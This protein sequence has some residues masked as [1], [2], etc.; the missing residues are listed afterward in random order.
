MKV[1]L[2]WLRDYVPTT[3]PAEELAE[4][5]T[6]AG[7][8]VTGME[9]RGGGW[10]KVW[11]GQ[12]L[13]VSP[14]PN[15]DRLRLVDVDIGASR[16]TVVSGAPNLRVGDKVPFA[17]VGARLIDG[18]TGQTLEL[19]PV[20]IRGVASAGMVC[21]EKELGLSDRH[22]GI[23][24]LPPDAPVGVPLSRYL[25]DTI[26]DIDITPN[27]PDCLSVLGVAREVASRTGQKLS[28]PPCDYPEEG[29]LTEEKASAEILD[30][31]LCPRYS[32]GLVLGVKVGPSPSWLR[33][34][35]EA[36]GMRPINNV[37]DIT[38]YVMIEMGQPLHAF[39]FDTLRGRRIIVRRARRGEKFTT[40]DGV[41]RELNRQMLVIADADRA[42]AL[43]GIMG[44][45][46]TEVTP[47]TTAVLL[48]AASF[49]FPQIRATSRALGLDTEAVM[50]FGRGLA[51][52]LTVPSLRRAV[53]LI[54]DLAGGKAARGLLD[55]YPGK[56]EPEPILLPHQEMKRL[57]GMELAPE[58]VER[59]LT[60]LGFECLAAPSGLQVRV[61]YWR[62]DI[63]L[64]ADL[65]EEVARLWGYDN[66]PLTLISGAPPRPRPNPLL[67]L[68]ERLRDLLVALG[69]QEAIN[70]ALTSV[71]QLEGVKAPLGIK[72]ANPLTR[73]Q[74]YLR[75]SLRPGLLSLLAQ[76]QKYDEVLRFFE[77]GRVYLTREKD[78]PME[79]EVA[80]VVVA[81]RRRPL[82]WAEKEG[83]ADFYDIKGLAQEL[84]S[85][86][87]LEPHFL[88]GQDPFLHPARQ[89]YIMVAGNPTGVLGEVHPQVA[90]G[91]ELKGPAYL[92]E[93]DLTA[94]LPNLP[95]HRPYRPLARFPAVHRD[96]A[97][98]VDEGVPVEK[99]EGI[100]RD[101]LMVT[102]VTLF[103]VYSGKQVPQGK[104]SLAFRVEYQSLGRT[105]TDDEVDAVLAETL[106]RL[107]KD[108]GAELRT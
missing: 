45:L 107:H 34:R 78:L 41:E 53:K 36:Y 35:L 4:K 18:H 99:V 2:S 85:R 86:L 31:D 94:I 98:V 16:E 32:A 106:D 67:Q 80:G 20:K 74:E 97:V 87:G 64:A 43:G 73:E 19:K 33:E 70:Y 57:L 79:R 26:L 77:L 100:L 66:V 91:F 46:D 76:N 11:V 22:E 108:L 25:G 83:E 96:I 69:L 58:E 56:T 101:A 5:L 28:L 49:T 54:L 93:L 104:K 15:A 29:P 48:E 30:P 39:D 89:A 47:A 42:V 103:D 40:L 102:G 84:L 60:S 59:I 52:G 75:T 3:L 90:E 1:P 71:G 13:E 95:P 62:S 10:E 37:V 92:L 72:V 9:V 68:K 24:V 7:L 63:R 82:S 88:P 12:V 6:M 8:E 51:P 50:R 61:P 14:H 17:G 55:T 44:G 21:S 23:M 27:R 105:L 81:G 65:V 38:N